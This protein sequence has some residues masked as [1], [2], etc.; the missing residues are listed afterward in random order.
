MTYSMPDAFHIDSEPL[1]DGRLIRPIGELD[2]ATSDALTDALRAALHS[3]ARS[4]VLDLSGVT[5]IDSAGV[6]CVLHAVAAS[7]A[8]AN[9]LCVRRDHG[10]QVTRLFEMVGAIDRLPYE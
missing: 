4:V 8:N 6:R 2:I 9:K 10:E 3:E 5:F 1:G 7:R